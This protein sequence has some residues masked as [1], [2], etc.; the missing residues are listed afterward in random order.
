MDWEIEE[1]Y[2]LLFIK[3]ATSILLSKLDEEDLKRGKGRKKSKEKT[4]L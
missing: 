4:S 2:L 1:K 3:K